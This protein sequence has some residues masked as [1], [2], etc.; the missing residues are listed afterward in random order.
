MLRDPEN[1][2]Q[3]AADIAETSPAIAWVTANVHG[4]EESGTDAALQ[5]LQDLADR[6]DC[7]AR[8]IRRNTVV[9]IVP[10]QN[11]DGRVADTRRNA[12]NFDLNRDWFARTQP[13]T[14]GKLKLLRRYP[15]PLFIDDHEMG[16]DDYFF[17]P[18]ADPVH[19]EIADR[20]VRWINDLYGAAMM[21]E[22]NRQEIPFFNYDIYDLLYMGYGDTVPTTGF[23]GA[24]MTF[25]KN[26]ADP[27]SQRLHEQYV[28]VW[29]SL[30]ALSRNKERVLNGWAASHRQ[31]YRQGVRGHLEPNRVWAPGNE[32]EAQVPN[33]R[34]R[35]Y[36]IE[37]G[38]PGKAKEVRS[39]VRRLQRMDVGVRT[40]TEPLRVRDYRPY[41][42]D[43]RAVVLPRGTFWVTMAQGQKHWVQ[44]MLGESSYV[45]FPYFYDV[46]AWSG[47]LLFN[48][49][50]GRS[51]RTLQP[52]SRPTL[53]FS[54]PTPPL[55]PDGAASI[56]L[57]Q[58]DD[59]V[60]YE[61]A[62]WM[63][64][65]FDEKWHVPFYEVT[66]TSLAEGALEAVDVLV[67]PHG[68]AETAYDDLG[69]AG[70]RTLREW[71]ADGGRFIGIRGGTELA[72]RLQLTTARLEEPTSDVP[73][74]LIR[75]NMARG[76]LARGV[77]DHVWSFYAYDNVM[78]LTDQESVAVRY[79]AARGRNW[80]VSGFERG[81]EEL[82]RTAV[83]A[84]ETYG[85][86]RVVSFAGEPNFRGF[87]DGTQQ[88]LWNAMFGGDPAPNAA[89]T[90]A[91]ADE[92]AAA[93]KSARRL[94]DYDGQ[95][96]ITVRLDAAAETQAILTDYGLQ[97]DGHRLGR[98]TVRYRLDVETAEDNPFVRQLVADLAPMGSD[99]LAVRV[100]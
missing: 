55:E 38:R 5:V 12:Y 33:E 87:T 44:A 15:A 32:V 60:G 63:R 97:P 73:G 56:G 23:L 59:E 82:G 88:I 50:G 34:V 41:G 22:F 54:Q 27:I 7:A 48:V 40:L 72:A 17:P 69:P 85:Q 43:A 49:A 1:T 66:S 92:R 11:P 16:A 58:L 47:P 89:S 53:L 99:I 18:N 57:W 81:A 62:G 93:S 28:A 14:D 83:V 95:L 20:S 76:P 29:T 24:G 84:D 64:W 46:T 21:R 94:V 98:H 4:N 30:T 78:S 9:V 70:R 36:F 42:R 65:L 74:S 2:A 77:G 96:V 8:Q 71:L 100:P 25:E 67:A 52:Q 90:E 26:N 75:A 19:H 6:T 86:G 91:T 37:R 35:H 61:S 80:F 31:A 68:D 13:E 39:L 79:P 3:Q 10:T 51:G 45:P